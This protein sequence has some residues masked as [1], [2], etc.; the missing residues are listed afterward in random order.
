MAQMAAEEL[1]LVMQTGSAMSWSH[2]PRPPF[3]VWSVEEVNRLD[4]C[5]HHWQQRWHNL[6]DLYRFEFSGTEQGYEWCVV[7]DLMSRRVRLQLDMRRSDGIFLC[8]L[9]ELLN[10][11]CVFASM[12]DAFQIG[13]V[14]DQD[15]WV[16]DCGTCAWVEAVLKNQDAR[17]LTMRL[18]S[19]NTHFSLMELALLLLYSASAMKCRWDDCLEILGLC[20]GAVPNIRVS[21]LKE[22]ELEAIRRIV[23][24][25]HQERDTL[26]MEGKFYTDA[27]SALR[28]QG[29]VV[30]ALISLGL[31]YNWA[32]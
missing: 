29:M 10:L 11:D 26:I 32:D 17:A 6:E 1:R 23:R 15:Q 25:L 16:A 14:P 27:E 24:Y 13:L 12:N 7:W 19:N 30:K 22:N 8:E 2:E 3:R 21:E 4:A 18:N 9:Y 5:S 28:N 20:L 31:V